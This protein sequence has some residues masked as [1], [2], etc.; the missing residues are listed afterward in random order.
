MREFI[1]QTIG[2]PMGTEQRIEAHTAQNAVAEAA[3]CEVVL[4]CLPIWRTEPRSHTGGNEAS[5]R[6]LGEY[7]RE[8]YMPRDDSGRQWLVREVRVDPFV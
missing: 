7:G 2:Q 1:I 6:Y 3:N 8:C 4:V 5:A